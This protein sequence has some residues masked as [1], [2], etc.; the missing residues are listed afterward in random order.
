ML[1]KEKILQNYLNPKSVIRNVQLGVHFYDIE[2]V[3]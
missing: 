2:L 1:N 3:R